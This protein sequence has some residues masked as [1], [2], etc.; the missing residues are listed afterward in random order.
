[1]TEIEHCEVVKNSIPNNLCE[2]FN[3][4]LTTLKC[5]VN[6]CLYYMLYHKL[7]SRTKI[8][9]EDSRLIFP[10]H[11]KYITIDIIK[12]GWSNCDLHHRSIFILPK[13]I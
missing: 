8:N 3:N 7:E 6:S 5:S 4:E 1:M 2:L 13:D 10:I 9:T 11:C 12:Q